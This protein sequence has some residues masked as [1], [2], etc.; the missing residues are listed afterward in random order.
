M[1]PGGQLL[2]HRGLAG[3]QDRLPAILTR[4][5]TDNPALP[6]PAVRSMV[7][8]VG[9]DIWFG[10]RSGSLDWLRIG[11]GRRVDG[12]ALA[13]RHSGSNPPSAATSARREAMLHRAV[14]IRGHAEPVSFTEMT[15]PEPFD[16]PGPLAPVP[17]SRVRR[18]LQIAVLLILVVSMVFLAWVSGRGELVVTPVATPRATTGV[19]AG[20]RLAIVDAAGRLVST[21]PAGRML[22]PLG[23]PGTAYSFPAW[24][25]D[26]SRVASVAVRAD[27]TAVHV[28]PVT[29]AG[30]DAIAPT[31]VY[32]SPD[33]DPFYVYWAPDSARITFLTNEA[34]GLALRIAPAD[35]AAAATVVRTGSPMYW[36]WTGASGLLVHHGGE[37]ADAFLGD[38]SPD[39]T[40]IRS[41]TDPLGGF[42]APAVAP[43]GRSRAFVVNGSG[44]QASIVVTA[45][46]GSDRHEVPVFGTAAFEFG[47]TNADLA[48][49]AADAPGP[50]VGLPV[51]PLR[52]LDASSRRVRVLVPGTIVGF[53]W[54]PDGK[55]IA[56]IELPGPGDDKVADAG[57]GIRLAAATA[58]FVVRLSFVDVASGTIRSGRTIRLG[59]LF[60]N[61]VLPYFDQYALS[62]RIWS[63]DSTAVALPLVADDD[64]TGI[65]LIHADGSD[66]QRVSDGVA[67]FWSP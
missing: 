53:F 35:A 25:P 18:G 24:S 63:A 5:P 61:Q 17:P 60:V 49:V 14:N 2:D 57:G 66:A 19:A 1:T 52:I 27:G 8:T 54:A 11:S 41:G 28:F 26:G 47:P 58:G 3:V 30:P 36:T 46:D 22:T 31:V 43:D 62:H 56:A 32:D 33:R 16:D 45:T 12:L 44:G 23:G 4:S 39:G 55:T 29:A 67:A 6:L 51:G 34:G 42:R 13:C 65:V 37:G 20:P 50:E 15:D 48:F 21:D 10:S 7:A 9:S 64:T 59:D 40:G 38:V